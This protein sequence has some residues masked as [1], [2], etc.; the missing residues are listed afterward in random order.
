KKV[1]RRPARRSA[2][3]TVPKHLPPQD[4][5]L[6]YPETDGK[7]MGETEYHVVNIIYLREAIRRYFRTEQVY[8]AADMFLYYVKGD[9]R[10]VKAPKVVVIRG[11]AKHSR[12]TSQPWKEKAL[13]CVIF[14]IP[15]ASPIQEARGPKRELYA[16]LGVAEFFLFA[17]EQ[18]ALDPPLQGFRLKGK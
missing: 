18:E 13:P 12:G 3:A 8:V 7:P 1:S 5:A 17:P 2:M 9:A 15:S 10:K 6:F 4:E 16:S 14:E 11:G